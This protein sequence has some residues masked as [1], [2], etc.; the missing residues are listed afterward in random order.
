MHVGNWNFVI[1]EMMS[2]LKQTVNESLWNDEKIFQKVKEK[3]KL[4]K[5]QSMT[6]HMAFMK[7]K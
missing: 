3:Q 4:S 2:S 7:M 1:Q 5:P 6:P